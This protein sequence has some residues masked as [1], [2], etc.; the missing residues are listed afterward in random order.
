M[1]TSPKE[2]LALLEVHALR[3]LTSLAPDRAGVADASAVLEDLLAQRV[4]ATGAGFRTK[5]KLVE[6]RLPDALRRDLHYL[7]TVRNDVLHSTLSE[8]RD[9]AR[10]VRTAKRSIHALLAFET[11]AA[12]TPQPAGDQGRPGTVGPTPTE[13]LAAM[14]SS[15]RQ[16]RHFAS[17]SCWPSVRSGLP[18]RW[19]RAAA[20]CCRSTANG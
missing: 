14:T 17:P 10:F 1:N 3:V 19:H 13:G 20:A 6:Q 12:T 7:A 18:M 4:G 16:K 5:L 15:L 8:I 11:S 9:P 2:Q